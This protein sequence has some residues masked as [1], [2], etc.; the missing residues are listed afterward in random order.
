MH[1]CPTL[2][3]FSG[4]G[5]KLVTRQATIRYLYHSVTAATSRERKPVSE[6]GITDAASIIVDGSKGTIVG[7]HITDYGIF[8]EGKKS[9]LYFM[10]ALVLSFGTATH[11][12][13]DKD[14]ERVMISDART[15]GSTREGRIARRHH[16][17]DLLEATDTAE[18][19]F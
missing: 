19:P 5:L 15:H 4:T 6:E 10:S 16:Q 18:G 7:T 14:A 11:A 3:V 8:N 2:W 12:Y 13:V 9:L 17:L 1:R